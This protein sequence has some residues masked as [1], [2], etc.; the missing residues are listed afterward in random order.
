MHAELALPG[1]LGTVG[2][3]GTARASNLQAAAAAQQKR[4]ALLSHG[5]GA[6][7]QTACTALPGSTLRVQTQQSTIATADQHRLTPKA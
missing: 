3:A 6:W 1:T 5:M 4:S 7:Q 2:R